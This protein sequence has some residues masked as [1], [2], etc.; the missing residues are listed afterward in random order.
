V[1][2]VAA[3]VA[4][5][6][7][8]PTAAGRVYNVAE[9]T[10]LTEAEWVAKV[11]AVVGWN[12]KVVAVPKGKLPVGLNTDQDLVVDST[13][14]RAELGYREVV[15]PDDALRETVRWEQNHLPEEPVDY[16]REDALLAE[17]GP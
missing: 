3:A 1:E 16:A 6:A 5:A 11:G 14:I 12:G 17:L 13:R 7:T 10:A 2:D 15:Q 9:P 4:L 8:S